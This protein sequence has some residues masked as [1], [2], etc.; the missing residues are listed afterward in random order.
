MYK[1]VDFISF[2]LQYDYPIV[3]NL[4]LIVTMKAQSFRTSSIF[5][6]IRLS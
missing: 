2:L 1:F 6:S 4:I 5:R 3:K